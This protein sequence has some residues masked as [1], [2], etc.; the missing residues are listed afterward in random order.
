MQDDMIANFD[1]WDAG[2]DAGWDA[3]SLKFKGGTAG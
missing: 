2:W 3:V 1:R